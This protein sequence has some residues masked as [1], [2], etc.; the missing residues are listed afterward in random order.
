MNTE[1]ISDFVIYSELIAAITG[2]IF[3]YKYGKTPLK[4]LL[5]LLWYITLTELIGWYAMENKEFGFTHD[6]GYYY[7]SWMY[8]L[9]RIVTFLTLFLIYS[10]YL[11]T[12]VFKKWITIFAIVYVLISIIN[13]SFIQS[14][15]WEKSEAP[16]IV[17][18]ILLIISIIFY[19]IEL[20]R[21]EKLLV[22]HKLLLFWVSVGLLLFYTGT[23]PFSLKYNGYALIPGTHKLFL[24]VY[25]LA[26]T[27]YLLFTFGF[28]WSRK[29]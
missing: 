14:F 2:T 6:N 18:S 19:F 1:L 24:I 17:G 21:S 12:K 20:L 3:F 4:F 11:K 10:K 25:I 29:E 13:W 27:M 16:K 26:I 9:L 8:N 22:F 7:I 28:I 5:F 23:I 15:I